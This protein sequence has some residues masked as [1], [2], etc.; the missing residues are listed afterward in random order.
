[1]LAQAQS[2][3]N[4]ATLGSSHWTLKIV[5][6]AMQNRLKEANRAAKLGA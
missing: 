3:E 6:T 4:I 5:K 2:E 1:M